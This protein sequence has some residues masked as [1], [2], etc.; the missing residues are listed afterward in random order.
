MK[1][2]G[3]AVKFFNKNRTQIKIMKIKNLFLACYFFQ[4]LWLELYSIMAAGAGSQLTLLSFIIYYLT[5]LF[6]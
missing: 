6:I 5:N 4:N 1:W 3:D 2:R